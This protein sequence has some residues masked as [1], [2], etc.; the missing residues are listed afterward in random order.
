MSETLRP[1]LLREQRLALGLPAS[2]P[3][4]RP[5]RGLLL[6]GGGLGMLVMLASFAMH[7]L[8]SARE[9][10]LQQ[11]VNSLTSVEQSVQRA[12]ARLTQLKQQQTT[13]EADT[14]R[15][16]DQLVSVRSGS[17][18][19]AQLQRVTPADVQLTTVRVQPSE[20]SISGVA[21]SAGGTGAYERVNALALNLEALSTVLRDGAVVQKATAEEDGLTAFN[22][23]VVIDPS[24]RSSPEELRALGADGLARRYALLRNRGLAL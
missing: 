13:L 21:R 20:I 14:R 22:L 5:A 1:D 17:A 3:P 15:I 10:A 12:Q 2:P 23:K 9:Q 24:V 7:Q 16:V 19:L 6:L 8:L 11:Q 18:F 4:L